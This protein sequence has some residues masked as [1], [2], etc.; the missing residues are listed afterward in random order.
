MGAAAAT[1]NDDDA[2]LELADA[3]RAALRVAD[4]LAPIEDDADNVADSDY[5]DANAGDNARGGG[6]GELSPGALA[7]EVAAAGR[8]GQWDRVSPIMAKALRSP[9]VRGVAGARLYTALIGAAAACGK[10]ERGLE[11]FDEM[12]SDAESR[13]SKRAGVSGGNDQSSTTDEAVEQVGADRPMMLLPPPDIATFMAALD[14]CAAIGGERSVPLGIGVT[15]QAATAARE[16]QE[17]GAT[18]SNAAPTDSPLSGSVESKQ[19]TLTKGRKGRTSSG[20]TN[21]RLALVLARAGEVCAAAGAASTAEA[22]ARKALE[23]GDEADATSGGDGNVSGGSGSGSGS[24]VID[25]VESLAPVMEEG[26]D[27]S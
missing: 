6:R 4:A 15:R 27:V 26:A 10:P 2:V 21:R 18:K 3:A 14:A 17:E 5:Y 19:Q 25:S 7:Q 8:L 9:S 13:R 22:L 23:M 24:D 1:G 12:S 11:V 16:Y 20:M